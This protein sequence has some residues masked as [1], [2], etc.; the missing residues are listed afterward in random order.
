V[1][2]SLSND[3]G[4]SASDRI[5]SD[6]TLSGSGDSNAVVTFREGNTV[7]G[8][9]TGRP[10]VVTGRSLPDPHDRR[11]HHRRH[12]DRHRRQYAN[13]TLS[14]TLDTTIATPTLAL[15]TTRCQRHRPVTNDRR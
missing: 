12:R 6:P 9:S 4:A 5:T 15:T 2:E 10:P 8:T 7:I 11:P 1:N 3:T 14:F 13:A